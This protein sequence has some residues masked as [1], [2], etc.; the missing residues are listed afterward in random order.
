M[1][2]GHLPLPN[3][4]IPF[5][6]N[7]DGHRGKQRFLAAAADHKLGSFSNGIDKQYKIFFLIDLS[8]SLHFL[9]LVLKGVR[10]VLY[11]QFELER[12]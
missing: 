10:I 2:M 5:L 11:K 6:A 8:I 7:F 9:N 1:E 4:E 12:K 3:F